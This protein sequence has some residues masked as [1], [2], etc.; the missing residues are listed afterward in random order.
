MNRPQWKPATP[1][2]AY[3]SWSLQNQT[4]KILCLSLPICRTGM[5]FIHLCKTLWMKGAIS[6]NMTRL[7]IS[8]MLGIILYK[9]QYKRPTN[10]IS[11]SFLSC[12]ELCCA[13]RMPN[14]Q[15]L[16]CVHQSLKKLHAPQL[17]NSPYYYS[18]PLTTLNHRTLM[19]IV[20]DGTRRLLRV[21]LPY[22]SRTIPFENDHQKCWHFNCI[23][24][25]S[26]MGSCWGR[27]AG[28]KGESGK[29]G[30]G[31]FHLLWWSHWNLDK[32]E[33]TENWEASEAP[34]FISL[35]TMYST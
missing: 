16:Y 5:I 25:T 32:S 14:K 2:E 26:C 18:R 29:L 19:C 12:F 33:V 22:Y 34:V 8:I 4:F 10:T 35:F 24:E 3:N 27:R 13:E 1:P 7:W 15:K 28:G 6:N 20:M 21:L 23:L 9:H 31:I 30:K 17:F 11:I